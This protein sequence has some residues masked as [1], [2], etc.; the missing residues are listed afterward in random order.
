MSL[1]TAFIWYV[2]IAAV[3][4]TLACLTVIK[5]LDEPRVALYRKYMLQAQR[6]EIPEGGSY[7]N[8]VTTDGDEAYIVF[9]A[10][11]A[12]V[13]RG[14]IPYGEGHIE[15]GLEDGNFSLF[16]QPE[17]SRRDRS[18][19][20]F[21]AIV[22]I[23]SLPICYLGGLVLCAVAFWRRR[24]RGP[25][26]KLERASA[27]ITENDLD[28]TLRPERGDELGRLTESFET[29]R[30]SLE[31]SWRD[32]WAQMEERR[33]LNA[34]FAHDLRTP[35]TVLK[36]HADILSE[37]IPAGTVTREEAAGELRVMRS[38]IARLENYVDA[39]ARL[40][41]LEDTEVHR[42][43]VSGGQLA[44]SLGDSARIIC[45][46]LAVEIDSAALAAELDIDPEAVFQVCENIFS[47][48]ARYAKSRVRITLSSGGGSFTAA[49]HDD[50]PGFS[51]EALAKAAN[52]FY[53][54][55]E[56]TGEHLG[57][58]LNIC[59]ILCRRH[60]GSLTVSNHP[61]GGAV[62]TARFGM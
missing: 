52:P 9:D 22:Q 41:R 30:S 32:L 27:R 14:E 62:V 46:P 17:Y 29:M 5:L 49:V 51:A 53:K 18:L 59:D 47:N 38:H 21:I 3:L 33:R 43:R 40:Q 44:A 25:I 6:V 20:R 24:L 56:S 48:A 60:G 12:E 2:L 45:A 50:G 31:N 11:G 1:R 26:V 28:F 7:Q 8:Y 34:A 16:I 54:G 61:G 19:S 13:E 57:L 58:G 36:G 15:V 4:A 55:R 37:S 39:M 42:E 23:S 35:L 10:S